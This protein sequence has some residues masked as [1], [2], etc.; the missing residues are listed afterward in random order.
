MV[1]RQGIKSFNASPRLVPNSPNQHHEPDLRD[2]RERPIADQAVSGVVD[3]TAG[4]PALWADIRLRSLDF[5]GETLSSM[6]GG[7]YGVAWKED[8]IEVAGCEFLR[9]H[10][11]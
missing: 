6:D 8:L 2:A 7:I 11:C 3:P 4:L 5:Q 9:K 1:L 10:V